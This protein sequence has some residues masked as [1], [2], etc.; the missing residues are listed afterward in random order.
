MIEAGT[1]V[2]R[3]GARTRMHS[4]VFDS[5]GRS[6][7]QHVLH[8][9][10]PDRLTAVRGIDIH[11][12]DVGGFARTIDSRRRYAFLHSEPRHADG[13]TIRRR[14]RQECSVGP[15]VRRKPILEPAFVFCVLYEECISPF[16]S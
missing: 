1:L 2:H 16:G 4:D 10:A 7:F 15:T 6:D 12:L 8:E 13:L 9:P 5:L 11:A 14:H 3:H